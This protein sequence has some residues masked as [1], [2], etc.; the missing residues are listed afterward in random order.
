MR[1]WLLDL[2]VCPFCNERYDPPITER[3]LKGWIYDAGLDF[4]ERRQT[5]G[6]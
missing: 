4:V 5:L 6:W 1:S 2:I 3:S